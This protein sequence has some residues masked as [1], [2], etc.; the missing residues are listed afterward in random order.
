MCTY[1]CES[2]GTFWWVCMW[3]VV[4]CVCVCVGGKGEGDVRAASVSLLCFVPFLCLRLRIQSAKLITYA[5][6]HTLHTHTHTYKGMKI[7]RRR[8]AY[9]LLLLEPLQGLCVLPR[10]LGIV[11]RLLLLLRLRLAQ[12]RLQSVGRVREG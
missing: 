4:Y 8:T 1:A 6:L 11:V 3:G 5:H 7:E 9:P 10:A 12:L 2:V